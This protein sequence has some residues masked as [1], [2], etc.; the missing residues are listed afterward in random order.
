VLNFFSK[1][2]VVATTSS[3]DLANFVTTFDERATET[4][5]G[6]IF[7]LALLIVLVD[8]NLNRKLPLLASNLGLN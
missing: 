8:R 6:A 7:G 2:E 5:L 4:K 1:F 3:F